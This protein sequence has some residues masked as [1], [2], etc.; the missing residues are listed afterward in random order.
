MKFDFTDKASYL[1]WRLQWKNDYLSLS[2]EIRKL[3]RGRKMFLRT[4]ERVRLELTVHD[5]VFPGPHTVRR[6]ISKI[7]NPE[8]GGSQSRLVRLRKEAAFQMELLAE[9][10]A[11]SYQLRQARSSASPSDAARTAA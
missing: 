5:R 6:L 3:K 11:L 1:A 8:S 9:A 4:Y 7:P 2:A 10:K